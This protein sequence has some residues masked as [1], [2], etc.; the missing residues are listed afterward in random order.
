MQDFN[1]LQHLW[2][3]D[4]KQNIL[5]PKQLNKVK[6]FRQELIR[7][8]IAGAVLLFATGLIILA[9]AYF[10]D[11]RHKTLALYTSMFIVS[12]LCFIQAYLMLTTA[13]K[14]KQINEAALPTEHLQQWQQ[15]DSFRKKRIHWNM[16]IYHLLLGIAISIYLRE[17]LTG[18]SFHYYLLTYLP[19]YSWILFSYFYLGKRQLAKIDRSI[20]EVIFELQELERQFGN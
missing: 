13:G 16:P 11:F 17:I 10:L 9:L 19:T 20:N 4:S 6:N 5:P 15:F 7:K 18:A 8:E 2:K 14:I 1:D 12:F 3:Q